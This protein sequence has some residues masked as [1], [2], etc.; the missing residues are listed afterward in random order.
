VISFDI[1]ETV[2][3]ALVAYL[4]PLMPGDVR[5]YPSLS[6]MDGVQ[7]PYVGVECDESDNVSDEGL[8]NGR[9]TLTVNLALTVE[10]VPVTNDAGA[11]VMTLRERN[12]QLRRALWEAI[13]W[14]DLHARI[15]AHNGWVHA[16]GVWSGGSIPVLFSMAHPTASIRAVDGRE[17]STVITLSVIA[18]P[19]EQ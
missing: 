1:E 12:R 18:Q 5:V 13:A 16:S 7:M 2:E 19:T 15:N 8:F 6:A 9:R 17:V 11:E 14:P 4:M 3:D 10:A